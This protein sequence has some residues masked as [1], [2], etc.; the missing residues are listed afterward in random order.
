[1][2]EKIAE[3]L[4]PLFPSASETSIAPPLIRVPVPR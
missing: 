2:E 1:M 3:G 4:N